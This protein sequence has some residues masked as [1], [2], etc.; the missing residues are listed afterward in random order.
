MI[1]G[2]NISNTFFIR[3]LH[4]NLQSFM[5]QNEIQARSMT[6]DFFSPNTGRSRFTLFFIEFSRKIPSRSAACVIKYFGMVL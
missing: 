5:V 2:Q 1:P 6:C 3:F 4:S